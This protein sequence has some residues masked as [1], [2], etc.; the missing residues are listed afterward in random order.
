[1]NGTLTIDVENWEQEPLLAIGHDRRVALRATQRSILL[2]G[3][4]DVL[5]E[6][7]RIEPPVKTSMDHTAA[8]SA[9]LLIRGT[10]IFISLSG[11]PGKSIANAVNLTILYLGGALNGPA[12]AGVAG[13]A[14]TVQAF[15]ESCFRLSPCQLELVRTIAELKQVSG[16]VTEEAASAALGD[17]VQEVLSD[18]LRDGVV[19]DEG[20]C[21]R[22]T[23]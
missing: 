1:M 18:L 10:R 14:S 16:C 8:S 9:P 17:D 20:G 12:E 6:R 13:V 22:I 19:V 15:Y 3:L 23:L 11:L 7:V 21:L 4:L 5:G 2:Q